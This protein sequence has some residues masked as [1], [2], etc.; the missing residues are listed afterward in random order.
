MAQ[1]SPDSF[2]NPL[3]EKDISTLTVAEKKHFLSI[4]SSVDTLRLPQ[5]IRTFIETEK[6]IKNKKEKSN[7]F[8]KISH[9]GP[10]GEIIAQNLRHKK[11]PEELS[12]SI[13]PTFSRIKNKQQIED[14]DYL[15][16]NTLSQIGYSSVSELL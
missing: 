7:F 12:Q 3:I 8:E 14:R 5:E 1:I 11:S 16:R 15:Y 4:L 9:N 2:I 6:E 13:I 10:S